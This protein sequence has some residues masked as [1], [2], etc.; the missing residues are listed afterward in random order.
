[1]FVGFRR[2][3]RNQKPHHSLLAIE[4]V[5]DSEAAKFYLGKRAVLI[6]KAQNARNNSRYRT[7]W[8]KVIATHGNS[9]MV[10]GRFKTNLPACAM[11]ETLRVMMY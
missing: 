4:G 1:M 9:G 11:G 10:R 7:I 8:G 6:R 5:H 2:S 3:K